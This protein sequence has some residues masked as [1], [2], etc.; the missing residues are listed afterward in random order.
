[1]KVGCRGYVGVYR[2]IHTGGCRGYV[3]MYRGIGV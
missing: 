1:M 3:G 2:D